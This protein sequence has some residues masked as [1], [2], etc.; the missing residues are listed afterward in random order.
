MTLPKFLT[1]SVDPEKLG[2]TV[3]GFLV[4]VIP[5]VLLVAGLT[6][7]NVGQQDLSALVDGIVNLTVAI[8]TALSGL[9]VLIGIVRKI[10]VGVGIIKPQV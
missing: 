6:H 3:K 7:I 2:L 5:V 10:L 1:S 9:M 4:G 8:S